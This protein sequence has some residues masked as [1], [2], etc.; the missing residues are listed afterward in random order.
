MST[1]LTSVSLLPLAPYKRRM[2]PDSD[3]FDLGNLERA[4]LAKQQIYVDES[5]LAV[6]EDDVPAFACNWAGCPKQF[7]NIGAYEEHYRAAHVNV[8]SICHAV[9]PSVRWLEMHILEQ[10]DAFFQTL[11]QRSN[12]YQCLVDGCKKKFKV[13]I[14]RKFHLVDAHKFPKSFDFNHH[15]KRRRTKHSK[16]DR[17]NKEN[18][19]AI[20]GERSRV[21]LEKTKRHGDSHRCSMNKSNA[22]SYTNAMDVEGEGPDASDAIAAI[23]N[24]TSQSA[25]REM[26]DSRPANEQPPTSRSVP[27]HLTFGRRGGSSKFRSRESRETRRAGGGGFACVRSI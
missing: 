6:H 1:T 9:Y 2:D 24:V 13:D 23:N 18:E 21:T 25:D 27:A 15:R 11:A 5:A 4:R 8:C 26:A 17:H 14:A 3:F 19:H 10:H 7:T 22:V 12:M 16:T 20:A